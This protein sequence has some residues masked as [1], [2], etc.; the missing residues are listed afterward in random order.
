MSTLQTEIS[1]SNNAP[2]GPKAASE[3]KPAKAKAVRRRTS[4]GTETASASSARQPPP[5]TIKFGTLTFK[6]ASEIEDK[7]LTWVWRRWLPAGEI[8]LWAGMPKV[9]KGQSL[10]SIAAI[11]SNGGKWPDGAQAEQ[12]CVLWAESEDALDYTLKP[13]LI[14]NRANLD[15]IMLAGPGELDPERLRK[16]V[17]EKDARLIVLSAVKDYLESRGIKVNP[18]NDMDVRKALRELHQ[19]I[20]GTKC[21]LIAV[22]H[23]N[24]NVDQ[25]NALDRFSG[26]GAFVQMARNFIGLKQENDDDPAGPRRLMRIGGNL[27]RDP[28]DLL[29]SLEHVGKPN[30]SKDPDDSYVRVNWSR[31][32][33]QHS[34][35]GAFAVQ[36]ARKPSAH[37]W[38]TELLINAGELEKETVIIREGEA[39]GYTRWAIEQAFTRDKGRTLH[40]EQNEEGRSVWVYRPSR[41]TLQR[42][43]PA[44]KMPR[45]DNSMH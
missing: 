3:A 5:S 33:F 2:P 4:E 39:A 44:G 7:E 32:D 18:N 30:G 16:L 14:A 45:P 20:V 40:H 31:A 8:T 22:G 28:D 12:G 17:L 26:S 38:L 41:A 34:K 6:P 21:A 36:A 43:L 11:V 29:F 35:T 27:G 25:P 9:G 42:E 10:A 1:P 15:K 19:C 24:K 13:R 23:P 37:E